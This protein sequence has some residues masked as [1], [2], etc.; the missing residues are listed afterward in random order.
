[1][2]SDRLTFLKERERECKST[3]CVDAKLG[4]N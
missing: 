2:T 4:A 1:M 3:G